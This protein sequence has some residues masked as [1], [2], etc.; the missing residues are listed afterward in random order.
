MLMGE[1]FCIEDLSAHLVAGAMVAPSISKTNPLDFA[2]LN[3]SERMQ[4]V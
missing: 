1:T 2:G 4:P 3:R